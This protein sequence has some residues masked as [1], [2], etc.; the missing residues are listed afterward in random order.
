[1]NTGKLTGLVW[2]AVLAVA[3]PTF[4]LAQEKAPEK[5]DAQGAPRGESQPKASTTTAAAV[6]TYK[7]PLRGAPAGRIGG[8]TR[9]SGREVFVLTVLAPDHN[10]LTV[11]EQ[12]SLYWFISSATSLP[13]EVTLMDL[14]TTK[15]VLETRLAAP[16]APGVHRIR[17]VD[18]GVRLET[19]VPYRWFVAI[20]P[21]SG[22]RSKD[23]LA[24]GAIERIAPPEALRAKLAG[25]PKEE[26]AALYAEAGVWY[27]A[28]AAISDLID[29]APNDAG[30]RTQRAALLTQVGLPAAVGQ[31]GTGTTQ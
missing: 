4:S 8:G 18:H 2:L 11:S 21:D 22:R 20:V 30:L 7:P 12:P 31:D 6:P 23:I 27:E 15:P 17:L 25:V 9:G 13:I 1:M 5:K 24:G 10:A 29:S 14:R 19:G 3:I 16:V 28:L 26:A